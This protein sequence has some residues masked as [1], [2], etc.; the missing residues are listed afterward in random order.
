MIYIILIHFLIYVY[1]FCITYIGYHK[2]MIVKVRK[3][4][5]LLQL[6]H[7]EFMYIEEVELFLTEI[8]RSILRSPAMLLV[9]K[10][11]YILTIHTL[12]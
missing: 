3:N 9:W 6:S 5:L 11:K 1:I 10:R 8:F 12:L 7:P 4:V 2:V